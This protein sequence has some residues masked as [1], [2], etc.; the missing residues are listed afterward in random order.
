MPQVAPEMV[1]ARARR[2]REAC[3]GR[4]ADWLRSLVG[5]RQR[6]LVEQDG[7]GHAENFA[8]ILVG[9]KAGEVVEA[10]VASVAGDWLVGAPT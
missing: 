5:T 10:V 6:V 3:A 7:R 8:P 1:R 4:R 9:G 2:L